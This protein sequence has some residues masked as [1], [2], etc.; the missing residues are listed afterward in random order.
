MSGDIY[1][2]KHKNLFSQECE[3]IKIRLIITARCWSKLVEGVKY[4]IA[5][6]SHVFLSFSSLSIGSCVCLLF[7]RLPWLC[8]HSRRRAA[9]FLAR[10]TRGVSSSFMPVAITTLHCNQVQRIRRRPFLPVSLVP[11]HPLQTTAIMQNL[12]TRFSPDCGKTL[13]VPVAAWFCRDSS[14]GLPFFLDLESHFTFPKLISV[15][16]HVKL[17]T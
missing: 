10:P 17:A 12:W 1:S 2:P 3:A 11:Y 15:R 8:S 5:A 6:T 9:P 7:S 13:L 14:H 16:F 4:A